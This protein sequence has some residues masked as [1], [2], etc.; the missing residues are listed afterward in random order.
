L[1]S[2]KRPA[3]GGTSAVKKKSQRLGYGAVGGGTSIGTLSGGM[4]SN[5]ASAEK[6]KFYTHDDKENIQLHSN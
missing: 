6:R 4:S 2:Q 3:K 1:L 5:Q